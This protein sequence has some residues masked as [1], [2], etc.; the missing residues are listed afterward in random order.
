LAEKEIVVS[1]NKAFPQTITGL[2]KQQRCECC[3]DAQGRRKKD[4]ELL[5]GEILFF[6]LFFYYK[7]SMS[8]RLM[9]EYREASN[10]KDTDIRLTVQDNL[11]KWTA[12]IQGFVLF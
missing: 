12:Y 1:G 8:A 2:L 5:F 11:Y 7:F 4:E 3:K 10:N 6:K 9:K